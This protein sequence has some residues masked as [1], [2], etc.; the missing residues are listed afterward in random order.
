[1]FIGNLWKGWEWLLYVGI[2]GYIFSSVLNYERLLE[3]WGGSK[4]MFF[5]NFKKIEVN[6]GSFLKVWY[7]IFFLFVLVLELLVFLVIIKLI[8]VNLSYI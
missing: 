6:L 1:M 5:W 2:S 3:Y 4:V 8:R 7:F